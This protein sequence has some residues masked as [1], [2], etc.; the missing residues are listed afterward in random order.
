VILNITLDGEGRVSIEFGPDVDPA[1]SE[2]VF[3]E[4]DLADALGDPRIG[5]ELGVSMRAIHM[6]AA[7]LRRQ[8]ALHP[9]V[10]E[11]LGLVDDAS[12]ATFVT[13]LAAATGELQDSSFTRAVRDAGH[14]LQGRGDPDRRGTHVELGDWQNDILDRLDELRPRFSAAGPEER[15]LLVEEARGAVFAVAGRTP[16]APIT[17]EALATSK[18]KGGAPKK[19]PRSTRRRNPVAKKKRGYYDVLSDLLREVGLGA[20]S[21]DALAKARERAR[22]ASDNQSR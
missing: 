20:A 14:I 10:R 4:A 1:E 22:I 9:A 7:M 5:R 11:A 8:S 21:P 13:N 18:S 19:E 15:A 12:Q 17:E 6:V 3:S 2:E 16:G